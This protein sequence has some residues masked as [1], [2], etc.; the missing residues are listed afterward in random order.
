[1]GV[2]PSANEIRQFAWASI[3]AGAAFHNPNRV[4]ASLNLGTFCSG[5]PNFSEEKGDKPT[6]TES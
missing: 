5:W 1:M 3:F 2:A 6:I 4:R